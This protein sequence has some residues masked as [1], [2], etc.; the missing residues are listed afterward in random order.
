M[1]ASEMVAIKVKI[2]IKNG[3]HAPVLT[4]ITFISKPLCKLS[5]VERTK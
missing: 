4:P 1:I 2:K 5:S 3:I